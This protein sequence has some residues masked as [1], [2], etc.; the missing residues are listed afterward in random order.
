MNHYYVKYNFSIFVIIKCNFYDLFLNSI[1]ATSKGIERT[2][3]IDCQDNVAFKDSKGLTCEHHKFI[4]HCDTIDFWG[5]TNEDVDIIRQNCPVTCGDCTIWT[6]GPTEYPTENYFPSWSPSFQLA[7]EE[8]TVNKMSVPKDFHQEKFKNASLQPIVTSIDI[9]GV[10]VVVALAM[11]LAV[12]FVFRNSRN[13]RRLE[14]R[15]SVSNDIILDD[16]QG[17]YSNNGVV[18]QNP[19]SNSYSSEITE[20]ISNKRCNLGPLFRHDNFNNPTVQES[21]DSQDSRSETTTSEMEYGSVGAANDFLHHLNNWKRSLLLDGTNVNQ[22]VMEEGN[23]KGILK[24]PSFKKVIA[25]RDY[26][27]EP[28]VMQC[29]LNKPSDIGCL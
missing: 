22:N 12:F 18:M 19:S 10:V 23:I 11:L 7:S 2:N 16:I 24:K 26:T 4:T 27:H 14:D 15:C 5:Y 28:P 21:I 3:E 25:D 17:V 6:K 20:R 13:C 1:H 9:T 8:V 29:P